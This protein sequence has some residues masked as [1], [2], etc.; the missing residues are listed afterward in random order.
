M[1]RVP[2]WIWPHLTGDEEPTPPDKNYFGKEHI[3]NLDSISR[4]LS[5]RLAQ[6]EERTRIVESKLVALLTLTS[7][8]STAVVAGLAAATTLGTLREDARSLAAIA[9]ILVFYVAAQLLFSLWAT[10]AGLMRRGYKQ[11]SPHQIVPQN[12]ENGEMYQIRLLNL[13]ANHT[14]WNEW[15]IDQ[16]VSQMAV[17]HV[18]LRNALTA[19]FALIVLALV[20]ASI[21]LA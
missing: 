1:D 11:L 18:A 4:V 19:T 17:A 14:Y 16:K 8:L 5:S 9:V 20:I 12:D 7:V 15:V 21:Q 2:D 6:V 3:G 13:Q 10:V